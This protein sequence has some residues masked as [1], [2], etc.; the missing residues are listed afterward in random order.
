M[1]SQRL[2]RLMEQRLLR[3]FKELGHDDMSVARLQVLTI[4]FQQREPTTAQRIAAEMGLSPVTVGRFVRALEEGGWVERQGDPRDGRAY[5]LAPTA[6]A[7]AHLQSFLQ[8]S[9]EFMDQAYA[10]IPRAEIDA[11]TAHLKRL[12]NDLERE[13]GEQD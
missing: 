7:R 3:T 13:P 6:K 8:V 12:V 11:W 10:G 9:D 5:L 2:I 4:L 1:H